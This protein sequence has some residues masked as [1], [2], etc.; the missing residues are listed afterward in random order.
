M[1]DEKPRYKWPRYVLAGVILFFVAAI[2][3]V[4]IAAWKVERERDFSAPVQ[5][6]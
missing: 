5:A 4:A 3:W 6:K 1:T 2:I